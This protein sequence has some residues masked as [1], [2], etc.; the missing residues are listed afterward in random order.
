MV[1]QAIIPRNE[2]DPTGADSKERGAIN[3]F[4][5]RM[6]LIYRNMREI[7]DRQRYTIVTINSALLEVNATQYEWLLSPDIL[8]N[9]SQEIQDMIDSILL[10]GGEQNLWFLNA[11]VIPAAIQGTAQSHANLT[12]Q[13]EAYARSRPTLDSL[14]TSEPYR[15]RIGLLRAREFEEMKNLSNRTK[16]VMRRTL[17]EGMALGKNPRAISQDLQDATSLSK[18]RANLIARTEVPGA[19]RRARMDEDE[20]AGKDLGIVTKQMHISAFSPTTRI[21]HAERHG[22]LHTIQEQREWWSYA[23]NACNCYLPGTKVAGRFK[24]GSKAM[25]AG[26]AVEI[27]TASGRNISVTLNHPVMTNRGLI[28]AGE[29]TEAD[30][31]LAYSVDVE[32]SDWVSALDDKHAHASIEDVFASLSEK[33]HTISAGVSTV[34]FHGDG[35]FINEN[36]DVVAID[37]FLAV[38]VDAKLSESLDSLALKHTDPIFL[39][40]VS[41]K[42]SGVV[43]VDLSAPGFLSGLSSAFSKLKPKAFC[44]KGRGLA[45]V[46]PRVTELGKDSINGDSGN[47]KI[48]A[49]LLNGF[50]SIMATLNL[51]KV[52]SLLKGFSLGYSAL[53]E[54]AKHSAFTDAKAFCNGFDILPANIAL[55]KVVNIRRFE[56]FGHVYDLEEESGLMVAGSLILSNC[57]CSTIAVLVDE[58]GEPLSSAILARANK[59]KAAHLAKLRG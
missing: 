54:P 12:I 6:N 24:A 23:K 9:L 8:N 33:S 40:A 17:S 31:L 30:Y 16:D 43:S 39:H 21:W 7:L 53:V 15:K 22:T 13:S 1:A 58:K 29:V 38:G 5:K 26:D 27:V 42:A 47:A 50:A 20:Q 10:Q 35:A 19:L 4:S 3:D 14:L 32:G 41:A 28:A 18:T 37:G 45:L 46:S 36:I 52:N 34:D 49:Q 59:N 51:G 2:M 57:K 56:Y 11:Y 55:D 48:G 25:Y 44:A